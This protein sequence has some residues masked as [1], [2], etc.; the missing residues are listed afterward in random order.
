MTIADD[1][2]CECRICTARTTGGAAL[3]THLKNDHELVPN[4]SWEMRLH[5]ATDGPEWSE[6][7]FGYYEGQRLLAVRVMRREREAD[8]PMRFADG[9]RLRPSGRAGED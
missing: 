3:L 9:F 7:T 8:D 2:P 1:D 4:D 6:N 5:A